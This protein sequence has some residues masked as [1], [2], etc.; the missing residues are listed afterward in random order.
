MQQAT[1]SSG[2]TG[3]LLLVPCSLATMVDALQV[4]PYALYAALAAATQNMAAARFDANTTSVWT[5][6][7]S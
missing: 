2:A 4:R 5:D 3:V 1:L 6:H 7:L